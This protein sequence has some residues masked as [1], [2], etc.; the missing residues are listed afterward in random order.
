MSV[1]LNSNLL[2]VSGII[3]IIFQEIGNKKSPLTPIRVACIGDSITSGTEYPS[4]LAKLLG[5]NYSIGNFGDSGATVR[6]DSSKPYMNQPA[7]KNAI[8]FEPKIIIIMLGT[9]DAN[10]DLKQNTSN[11][12]D[13]YITLISEF[14]SLESK[15][16]VLIVLSPPVFNNTIGFSSEIFSQNI[17]PS[18]ELVASKTNL[19]IIEVYSSL[20]RHPQ[21]FVDGVHPT[22]EGAKIIAT[23]IYNVIISD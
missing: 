4:D 14:Q 9:N 23:I 19:P 13:D 21:Y 5:S 1:S 18:I 8:E 12:V 17:V 10:P 11:F 22:D 2:V 3:W 20:L 15:P 6:L 7:F 16:K